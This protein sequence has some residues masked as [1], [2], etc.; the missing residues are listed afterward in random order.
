MF[1]EQWRLQS[2]S[3]NPYPAV[4]LVTTTSGLSGGGSICL[5]STIISYH[6]L[7][8]LASKWHL[9]Y[10]SSR[11]LGAT[12]YCLPLNPVVESES[13]RRLFSVE[14]SFSRAL[15]SSPPKTGLIR[16]ERPCPEG[17]S[18]VLLNN[19]HILSSFFPWFPES[20]PL[21]KPCHWDCYILL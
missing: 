13:T 19:N 9:E 6:R 8:R 20:P 15:L 10:G 12:S 1:L 21:G 3:E 5:L 7:H 14:L 16:L 17:L 11:L 2:M 18:V 4:S